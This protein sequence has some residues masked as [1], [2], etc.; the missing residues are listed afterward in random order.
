MHHILDELLTGLWGHLIGLMCRDSTWRKHWCICGLSG[1]HSTYGVLPWFHNNSILLYNLQC[2]SLRRVEYLASDIT[3]HNPAPASNHRSRVGGFCS[4]L[5]SLRGSP[6]RP[7]MMPVRTRVTNHIATNDDTLQASF[8]NIGLN[9][10]SLIHSILM[11]SWF[12]AAF[13]N[14]ASARQEVAGNDPHRTI[15][16]PDWPWLYIDPSHIM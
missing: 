2:Y 11:C 4:R 10:S 6:S 15:P 12:A 13:T 16:T 1:L 7:L 14:V 3:G 9:L 8:I 5:L